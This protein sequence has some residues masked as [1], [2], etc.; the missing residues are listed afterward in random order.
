MKK[1]DVI[2]AL[3]DL[4]VPAEQIEGME[5]NELRALL[6]EKEEVQDGQADAGTQGE[7]GGTGKAVV[8]KEQLKAPSND[9]T[10]KANN[11]E[12]LVAFDYH[13]RL[14]ENK[15]ISVHPQAKRVVITNLGEGD[16]YSDVDA[17]S[18][19]PADRLE[20][21]ASKEFKGANKVFVRSASRPTV[22]IEQFTN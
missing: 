21:G 1:A 10:D 13:L 12:P 5:Y 3:K 19:A 9:G 11:A 8:E 18:F 16:L 15:I 7:E 17:I 6:K 14:Y 20:P 4:G 2:K 22:R